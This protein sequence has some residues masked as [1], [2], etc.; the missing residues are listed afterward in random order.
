MHEIVNPV[1]KKE[2]WILVFIAGCSPLSLT[3]WKSL[4]IHVVQRNIFI[5]NS[6]ETC[7]SFLKTH[8]LRRAESEKI[9]FEYFLW[10]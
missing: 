5:S 3:F 7:Q 9:G 8:R 2:G 4:K 6:P 1:L 10:V